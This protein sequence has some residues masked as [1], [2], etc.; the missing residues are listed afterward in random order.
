MR[1]PPPRIVPEDSGR[2]NAGGG[3][4]ETAD[5]SPHQI[6][7]PRGARQGA[8][9]LNVR[10]RCT[11]RVEHREVGVLLGGLDE[12]RSESG[13]TE[14]RLEILRQEIARQIE[15]AGPKTLGDRRGG[16]GSAKLDAIESRRR[17]P[18]I[19]RIPLQN[20]PVGRL[21]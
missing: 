19:P 7:S 13:L 18:P 11:L 16:K 1:L 20:R 2:K 6:L 21:H 4:G 14:K 12:P 17:V 10:A 5:R 3:E 15:L 8:P 9:Q